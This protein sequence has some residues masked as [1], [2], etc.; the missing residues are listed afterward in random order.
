[1]LLHARTLLPFAYE[2]AIALLLLEI[3]EQIDEVVLSL[4]QP[5]TSWQVLRVLRVAQRLQGL[6]NRLTVRKGRKGES[7]L[8]LVGGDGIELDA[9]LPWRPAHHDLA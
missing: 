3:V 7:F 9:V 8:E 6:L 5:V 1:M 2:E 4:L